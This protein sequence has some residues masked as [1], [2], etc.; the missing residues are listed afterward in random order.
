[1]LSAAALASDGDGFLLVGFLL[2]CEGDFGC[3]PVFPRQVRSA[4]LKADLTRI[5]PED[6]EMP[7]GVRPKLAGAGWD[8][9]VVCAAVGSASRNTEATARAMARALRRWL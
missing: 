9:G 8:G 3:I 7:D 6:Q 5:E 2:G 1:M 4:R